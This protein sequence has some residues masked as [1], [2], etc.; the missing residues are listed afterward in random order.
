M[1]PLHHID[2]IAA[3]LWAAFLLV[4][5]AGL[6]VEQGCHLLILRALRRFRD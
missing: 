4:S 3:S 6:F 5:L 1:N 2:A